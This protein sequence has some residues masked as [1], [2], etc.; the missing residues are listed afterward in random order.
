MLHNANPGGI[1]PRGGC[2]V[3]IICSLILAG[4]LCYAMKAGSD[5]SENLFYGNSTPVKQKLK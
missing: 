1:A 2:L 4:L 3:W 5:W